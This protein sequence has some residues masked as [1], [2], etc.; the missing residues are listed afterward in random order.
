MEWNYYWNENDVTHFSLFEC[1]GDSEEVKPDVYNPHYDHNYG[2][3]AHDEVVKDVYD[4][5]VSSFRFK[6]GEYKYNDNDNDNDNDDDA[7]SC[8]YDH[9]SFINTNYT[10]THHAQSQR[11][12]YDVDHVSDDGDVV[13]NDDE[14][15]D[16]GESKMNDPSHNFCVDSSN[17]QREIDRRFWETCLGT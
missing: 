12:V 9:S 16:W 10:N 11:L 17:D 4:Q 7:Q 2:H 15:N 1:T 13:N 5:D 3:H 8:S 6:E 14:H